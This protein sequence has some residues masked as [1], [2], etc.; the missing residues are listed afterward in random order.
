MRGIGL[1]LAL[2]MAGL[3]G[4][5]ARADCEQHMEQLAGLLP[6]LP[7]G[8]VKLMVMLDINFAVRELEEDDE[9]ECM[10]LVDHAVR[11]IKTAPGAAPPPMPTLQPWHG[12]APPPAPPPPQNVT[13]NPP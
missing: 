10:M 8:H 3:W 11:V 1:A 5:T 12:P 9:F 2:V 6:A 13:R 4:G 7:D